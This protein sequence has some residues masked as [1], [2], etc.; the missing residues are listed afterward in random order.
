MA[1]PYICVSFS[2]PSHK[3]LCANAKLRKKYLWIFFF[4]SNTFQEYNFLV[5]GLV[6]NVLTVAFFPPRNIP[7]GILVFS[8]SV[9]Q[10]F[11]NMWQSFCVS[12]RKKENRILQRGEKKPTMKKPPQNPEHPNNAFWICSSEYTR[13]FR[14][15]IIL[16]ILISVPRISR[17]NHFKSLK[18]HDSRRNSSPV[19]CNS[20]FRSLRNHL[21]KL[22]NFWSFSSPL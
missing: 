12:Y 21:Q 22:R 4:F 18:R 1:Y 6:M 9:L 13:F 19:P 3:F 7:K 8:K 5:S 10:L 11:Y 16:I 14:K 15:K 20:N 17:S 2:T